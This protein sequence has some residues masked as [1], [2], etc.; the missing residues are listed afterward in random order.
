M[1]CRPCVL[2]CTAGRY[3]FPDSYSIKYNLVWQK[4]LNYS[5]PFPWKEVVAKTEVPYYLSHLNAYGPP[6]DSRHTYVKV[7]TRVFLRHFILKLIVLPTQARDKHRE[8]SKKRRVFFVKLDWLA[9]V[10][11]LPHCFTVVRPIYNR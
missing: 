1:S 5:G 9:W 11:T 7:G 4:L 8:N 10:R 2:Y 6:M 3:N